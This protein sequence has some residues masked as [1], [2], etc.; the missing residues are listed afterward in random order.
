VLVSIS[1]FL[2]INPDD[3]LQKAIK[4][5]TMRFTAMEQ[6]MKAV[7]KEWKNLTGEEMDR[8]WNEAKGQ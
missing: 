8:L 3:A 7:S 2:K 5:F 6:K 1:R 4:K